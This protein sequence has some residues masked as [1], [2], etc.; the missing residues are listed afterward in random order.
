MKHGKQTKLAAN[1]DAQPPT[2]LAYDV[3]VTTTDREVSYRFYFLSVYF[4]TVLLL[5][6]HDLCLFYIEVES[7]FLTFT[8]KPSYQCY[9]LVFFYPP[10]MLYHQRISD[11][12]LFFPLS[13][14]LPQPHPFPPASLSFQRTC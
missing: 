2:T 10:I 1:N 9:Q 14:F 8:L 11:C 7:C 6:C 13:L 3:K 4:K 12:S 5:C